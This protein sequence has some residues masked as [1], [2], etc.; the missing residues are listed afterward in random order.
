MTFISS[1]KAPILVTGARGMLG[2]DLVE[3]LSAR[4][5]S[6]AVLP[7]D[8]LELDI[9]Q[10]L[11]VENFLKQNRISLIVNAAAYTDV[12]K[13]ET[14]RE[15]AYLLNATGPENLSVV[16]NSLGI[17]IVHFSTDYVFDG[18]AKAPL[19]EQDTPNPSNSN[20]YGETKFLG[21]KAVLKNSINLVLRVQWLYGK[22]RE[23]FTALRNKSEF[24]PFVDQWGAPSWTQD[25]SRVVVELIEQKATGLFH[26]AYDDYANWFEV[27]EFVVKELG[28]STRLIP[29]KTEE[30]NL[31]A[32]RPLYCVMSNKKILNQLGRTSLGSWKNSLST[33][34]K[35][36]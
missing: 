8:Y 20:Y 12:D 11:Q 35:S 13:A 23:R 28:L 6:K 32:Q 27:F 26:F 3:A 31:P 25:V 22:K 19:T 29:R 33:F 34:L 18:L 15:K 16:S 24:T 17:P 10:R 1:E 21:E 36:C 5:G 30:V 4:W 14:E 7:T 9:T 2:T